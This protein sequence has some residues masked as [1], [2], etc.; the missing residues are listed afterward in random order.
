ML[1]QTFA[2][3]TISRTQSRSH[4]MKSVVW[5]E[6]KRFQSRIRPFMAVSPCGAGLS[7][8]EKSVYVCDQKAVF[9]A[10]LTAS[11]EPYFSRSQSRKACWH[12]SQWHSP[13][14]SL[15]RCHITTAG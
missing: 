8:C 14:N 13:P 5:W 7:I 12:S 6:T 15:D 3:G 2:S 1:T 11:S 9:H 10:R 4:F